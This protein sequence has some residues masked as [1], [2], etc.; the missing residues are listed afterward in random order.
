M[1]WALHT[2]VPVRNNGRHRAWRA[3]AKRIGV[4]PPASG[5]TGCPATRVSRTDCWQPDYRSPL[6]AALV[7]GDRYLQVIRI[8]QLE[9]NCEQRCNH[10]DADAARPVAT[11][12][13]SHRRLFL[14]AAAPLIGCSLVPAATPIRVNDDGARFSPLRLTGAK[15]TP[16]YIQPCPF[17]A[18]DAHDWPHTTVGSV[19]ALRL[20][21]LATPRRSQGPTRIYLAGATTG[22]S[23]SLLAHYRLAVGS[24]RELSQPE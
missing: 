21:R 2:Q 13:G 20:L 11:W 14:L 7:R 15:V 10:D 16:H 5:A 6:G 12:R 18:H 23:D 19:L 17:W 3:R 4:P 22:A 8:T 24:C 9:A 1:L